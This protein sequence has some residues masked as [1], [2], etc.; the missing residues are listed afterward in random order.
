M[1]F[2]KQ[3]Q[4]DMNSSRNATLFQGGSPCDGISTAILLIVDRLLG[5]EW[6]DYG[7]ILATCSPAPTICL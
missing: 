7:G 4:R 3:V 6:E 5:E 1:P 2:G